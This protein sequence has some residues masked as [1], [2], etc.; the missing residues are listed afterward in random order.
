[1]ETGIDCST[2]RLSYLDSNAE[3]AEMHDY[4]WLDLP[5]LDEETLPDVT[6]T[7]LN[8]VFSQNH[9]MADILQTLFPPSNTVSK[10][11]QP[12]RFID[13]TNEL[14]TSNPDSER[15]EQLVKPSHSLSTNAVVVIAPTNSV[16]VDTPKKPRYALSLSY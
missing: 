5:A 8:D 14:I 3:F 2:S 1:M 11:T 12:Y 15:D 4:W 9:E 7:E 10:F 13:V 6:R 16:G